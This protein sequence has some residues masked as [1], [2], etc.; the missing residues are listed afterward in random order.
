MQEVRHLPH[1]AAVGNLNPDS[2]QGDKAVLSLLEKFGASLSQPSESEVRVR[3]S[4]L[5]GTVINAEQ[6]PDLVP[7]LAVCAAAAQGETRICGAERLRLKESDRLMTV[8]ELLESLGA[9]VTE[10]PGELLI[11]GAGFDRT[12][13]CRV[14]SHND[15]RIAM[16]AAVA[17]PAVGRRIW[18]EDAGASAKSYPCF[19]EDFR[20]LGGEA[21]EVSDGIGIWEEH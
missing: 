10:L 8:R 13:T 15:H 5:R 12:A 6:I 21:K 2:L 14:N 19:F 17:A 7:V 9:A 11:S 16:A 4:S 20:S 18:I 3:A 1:P